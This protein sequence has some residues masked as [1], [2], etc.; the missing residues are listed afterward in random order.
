MSHRHFCDFAWHNWQC[1]EHCHC[2]CG[3]PMEGQDHSNC[4]VELRACPEHAAEQERRM[5]AAMSSEPDAA[6]MQ[7]SND[8]ESALPVA[9]ADASKPNR[10]RSSAGAFI[11]TTCM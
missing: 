8:G 1:V 2:I 4:S 11:A 3:L 5:A 6:F 10:A 9:N 7:E